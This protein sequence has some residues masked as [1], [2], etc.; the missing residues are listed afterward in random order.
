MSSLFFAYPGDLDT[1]TGGYGYD[2]R[3]I[4]GLRELGWQVEL[5]PLGDGFP[6]PTAE[7]LVAAGNSLAALPDGALLVVDGLAFGVLDE[8]AA[9]LARRLRLVALVHHPLCRENG[10]DET[11]AKALFEFEQAALRQAQ[12]VIV[13]SPATAEQV[14][15]LFEIR[16]EKITTILPGTD[17]P[18]PYPR[19]GG[20]VVK[21]LAVGTVVPRKGYDLLFDALSGLTGSDAAWQLDIV[22]GLDADPACYRTLLKQLSD[23]GLGSQVTFHGAV[24]ADRLTGFYRAAHVFVLASRYEGYGMAYTEALAH[25]LPVIGSGG[26]AVRDT[27]PESATLYCGTEDVAALRAALETL[28]F[29][30]DKRAAYA[31]AAHTAAQSLPDWLQAAARFATTLEGIET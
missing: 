23:L 30:T 8:A 13:T 21:L 24:S 6:F 16:K 3:I 11:R 14:H 10:L 15:D 28:I 17:K 25:G 18:A 20:D 26:G 27:L 1:P 31:A 9:R 29:H 7:T 2:R 19:P 22:G 12:H 5:V 4:G